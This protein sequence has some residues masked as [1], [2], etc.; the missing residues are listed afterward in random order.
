MCRRTLEA[1]DILATSDAGETLLTTLG[2]PDDEAARAAEIALRK[3]GATVTGTA[4]TEVERL[5]ISGVI[6]A[7]APRLLKKVVPVEAG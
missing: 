3:V 7:V 2:D 1:P 6:A 5:E 4:T